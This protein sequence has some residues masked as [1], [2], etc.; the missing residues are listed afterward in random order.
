LKEKLE[1]I[2]ESI[3]TKINKKNF[4]EEEKTYY[5]IVQSLKEQFEKAMDDDFNT[6]EAVAILFDFVNKSNKYL[7][8]NPNPNAE[9]CKYAF[10]SL[11]KLGSVLTL[12]QPKTI[13]TDLGDENLSN[14]LQEIILKYGGNTEKKSI[15]KLLDIILEIR[16]ESRKRKDWKTSDDIRKKLEDIGF[17]IQDTIDGSVWRKK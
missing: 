13:S 9:L 15:D 5:E 10:D 7:E 14:K 2:S 11:I 4:D 1:S 8:D 3:S 16:T 17:E 6:P 12:F